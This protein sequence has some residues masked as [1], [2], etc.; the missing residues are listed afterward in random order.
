MNVGS[1]S[2]LFWKPVAMM[3]TFIVSSRVSSK[4]APKITVASSAASE[5]MRSAAMLMSSRAISGDAVM[6]IRI[7]FAPVIV[8][9]RSGLEIAPFAA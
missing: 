7:P 1:A 8:V 4:A 6:L 5:L 9:S 3:E 2:L